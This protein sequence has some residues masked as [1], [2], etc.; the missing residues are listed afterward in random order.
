[1]TLS[2]HRLPVTRPADGPPP[3]PNHPAPAEWDGG[4]RPVLIVIGVLLVGVVLAYRVA[5]PALANAAARY[6]PAAAVEAMSKVS[7]AVLERQFQESGVAPARREAVVRRFSGLR[8]PPGAAA[9][10]YDIVFR[11]SEAIGANA[12]AL[13]SGTIVVTD[14][15]VQ[16]AAGDEEILAV[17]AHE[18]GHVQHRHGLRLL[19][20]SSFARAGLSWLLGDVSAL[21]AQVS[22]TVLDAKYSRDFER[23]ADRFALALLDENGISRDHFARILRRLEEEAARRGMGGS[24]SLLAYLSSHP[25][26]DERI[27]AIQTDPAP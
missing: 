20:Q 17:L 8:L 23:E 2:R 19:F 7:F 6:V 26:T 4:L 16:L 3:L 9:A 10:A 11:R 12:L 18:A 25:V 14:G 24:G 1:M 21:A 13:P 15:L 5:V 27:E 22:G